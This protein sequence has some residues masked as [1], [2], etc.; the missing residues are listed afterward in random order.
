MAFGILDDHKLDNVPGTGLLSAKGSHLATEEARELKRGTGK[1]SHV[2]LIPQPSDDPRD[3][4]N[5]P[6]W[7]KEVCFWTLVFMTGLADTLFPLA[8]SG[9][10]RL[11]KEFKVSVDEVASAF[12][13]TLPGAAAFL[14]VQTPI[15]VKYGLRIVYLLTTFLMFISSAWTALSPNLASIRV[16]RVF[17]GFGQAASKCLVATSIEHLYFVP[18]RGSRPCMWN[19][20]QL[21]GSLLATLINGYVIE[22]LSWRL[23]FWFFSI[24]CGLA[25]IAILFFVPEVSFRFSGIRHQWNNIIQTTYHRRPSPIHPKP[26]KEESAAD[27][28]DGE[29]TF[30]TPTGEIRRVDSNMPPPNSSTFFA[31]L[32]IYNGTF[33]ADSVWEIF[34]RPFPF[35]LSPVTWF[36]FLSY[37]LP[38]A[39]LALVNVCSST[40]FSVTYGFKPSQIGLTSIGSMTGVLLAMAITGPLNDWWVIWMSRRNRGIHEPEFRLV[41]ML[42]MLVGVFG[43]VG[44]AVGN[45]NDMPWI[46]AVACLAMVHFSLIV[47]G[48]TR[49]AHLIDT[50]GANA[51]HVMVLTECVRDLLAYGATFFVNG[52]ILSAGVKRTLLA[53]GILQ[54]VLSL[55]CIPMWVFGKRVRSFIARHPRLFRGDLPATDTPQVSAIRGTDA[56]Y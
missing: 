6:R 56:K 16:S 26:T 2:V 1:Y 23:G 15:T 28:D 37:L 49:V 36:L 9:Y 48:T 32:K 54:A 7:K 19:V 45:G 18:E 17:Q 52:V 11:A 50:H 4:L 5:W 25:F 29:K 31:Q 24:G 42:G 43:F 55:T 3:P 27:K 39:F 53:L 30:R 8:A 20:F 14:L 10:F 12:G 38:S 41:F 35:I 46:G 33:S 13:A 34:L 51:L 22:D 44:W 47:T 40:I 21:M